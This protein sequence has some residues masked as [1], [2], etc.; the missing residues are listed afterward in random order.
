MDQMDEPYGQIMVLV[1]AAEYRRHGI[2][3]RLVQ[4]AEAFFAARG[5]RYKKALPPA[6]E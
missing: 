3:G 4:A 2:G 1:I 6:R 5:A